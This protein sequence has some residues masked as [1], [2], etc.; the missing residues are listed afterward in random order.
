MS[1]RDSITIHERSGVLG[2]TLYGGAF[3]IALP[4][5]L[6]AWAWTLD[7]HVSLPLPSKS[8]QLPAAGAVLLGLLFMCSA[9]WALW[10]WG[11][12]LP[13][14][15]YPTQ[16]RVSRGIYR[17]SDHPIYIGAVLI[18]GGVA[19]LA[20]SSSTLWIVLPTLWLGCLA[21][22]WGYERDATV[23]RLGHADRHALLSLPPDDE[24]RASFVEQCGVGIGLLVPWL[25][26]YEM[27]GHLPA[28]S[29]ISAWLPFE[30]EARV[31]IGAEPL[32]ASVY[33]VTPLAVFWCGTH[34]ALRQW[35]RTAWVALVCATAMYIALPIVSVP[36]AFEGEGMLAEMLRW[37]RWDGMNGRAAF[38]SFH[39]FWI[40]HSAAT[41]ARRRHVAWRSIAWIWAVGAIASCW[42]TGM[43][44]IIDLP[45]GFGLYILSRHHRL[46]AQ[47][48]L[49]YTERLANS[50]RE[51]RIGPLRIISH[52]WF[53]G[54]AAALGVLIAGHLAGPESIVGLVLLAA[55]TLLG[56]ALFGQLMVGSN[57]LLRPFGY[58]GALIGGILGMVLALAMG[59][60]EWSLAGGL[61]IAAPWIQAIGRLRC[62]VQGCCHGRPTPN[63]G[64]TYS[65]PR[66]RVLY[67]S[68]M[69]FQNLHA[70]QLYSLLGNVLIGI[71]LIRMAM[72]GASVAF[73]AGAYLILA[74]MLRFVEEHYRGEP[75]T[76]SWA[77]L[78]IYQW[79][80]IV[81]VL[82]GIVCS[83]T[84]MLIGAGVE[85]LVLQQAAPS[86]L[87]V[88]IASVIGVTYFIA[89][90][91]DFPTSSRRFSRLA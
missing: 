67:H 9:W 15:A 43:H 51:C 34:A 52:A 16:R 53:A 75:K 81:S 46:I 63:P 12:G 19:I 91:V 47:R 13:M 36:R 24:R 11:G 27:V 35:G 61:A 76:H 79:F 7:P 44:A 78:R 21:L 82:G 87:L 68:N 10:R 22:V 55:L 5:L 71:S 69:G 80:A 23:K 25:V 73:I 83:G 65:H 88:S 14:N 28:R 42:L 1:P 50:W 72:E 58:Y 30:R 64:I 86:P 32:Y 85:P 38:P 89:M 45:A 84:C 39:V 40:I 18:V 33:I 54:S 59:V 57:Q 60:A 77:G 62:L 49:R 48:A 56:A 3:C 20:G 31:W 37:E 17:L 41:I 90:G 8:W 70:T 26:I 6:A 29:A 66:S 4:S 2:Q 74:G